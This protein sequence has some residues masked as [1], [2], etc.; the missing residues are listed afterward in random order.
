MK[1]EN[2]AKQE[3]IDKIFNYVDKELTNILKDDSINKNDKIDKADVLFNM[4][5]VL[6]DYD[7]NM[8]VLNDY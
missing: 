8:K 3:I 6:K 7:I 4:F 2:S 5:K 1:K